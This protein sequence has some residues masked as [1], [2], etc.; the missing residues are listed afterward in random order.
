MPGFWVTAWWEAAV[1]DAVRTLVLFLELV[2][3][4]R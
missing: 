4:D 1:D 3:P 2:A